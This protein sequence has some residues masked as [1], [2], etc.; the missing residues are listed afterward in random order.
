VT[1]YVSV[2]ALRQSVRHRRHGVRRPRT[3][4]ATAGRSPFSRA[5]GRMLHP[6]RAPP[7][8]A[9]PLPKNGTFRAWP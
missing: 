5:R 6:P 4:P 1:R 7:P 8:P 3:G 2:C 9:P